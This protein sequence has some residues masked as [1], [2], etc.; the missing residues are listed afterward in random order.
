MKFA[1]R[2]AF[3]ILIAFIIACPQKFRKGNKPGAESPKVLLRYKFPPGGVSVYRVDEETVNRFNISTVQAIQEVK[4]VSSML[5][6]EK[7]VQGLMGDYA[8]LE[9]SVKS[10]QMKVWKENDLMFDSDRWK[11]FSD[12][13]EAGVY[14][15]IVKEVTRY[16]VDQFGK[17]RR[18]AGASEIDLS[19][20][21]V[22]SMQTVHTGNP[23]LPREEV[24]PGKSWKERRDIPIKSEQ[25]YKGVMKVNEVMSLKGI[26]VEGGRKIAYLSLKRDL[27]INLYEPGNNMPWK[28]FNGKG[29]M[30]GNYSFDI[31]EGRITGSETRTTIHVST[32]AGKPPSSLETS[33]DLNIASKSSLQRN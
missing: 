11:E 12:T 28:G 14:L 33:L 32:R 17:M 20:D 4:V 9:R 31:A 27:I 16:E 30:L 1:Y 7:V 25:G 21:M 2:T 24:S 29:E 23:I 15:I 19:S 18:A 5:V 26:G 3:V 8:M 6:N 10:L 13:P 22:D